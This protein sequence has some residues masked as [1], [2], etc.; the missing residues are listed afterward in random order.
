M[1][2]GHDVGDGCRLFELAWSKRRRYQNSCDIGFRRN[3]AGR[4]DGALPWRESAARIRPEGGGVDFE[5]GTDNDFN[6]AI[7]DVQVRGPGVFTNSRVCAP[8]GAVMSIDVSFFFPPVTRIFIKR[9]RDNAILRT[10]ASN[11]MPG[12]HNGN[13]FGAGVY[14]TNPADG[15]CFIVTI[16]RL[17]DSVI[18]PS[19][20]N[21]DTVLFDVN[22]DGQFGEAKIKASYLLLPIVLP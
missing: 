19:Q 3:K 5:D 12:T 8:P 16:Q 11:L 14:T 17:G 1:G 2:I 9:T 20:I 4:P 15:S 10:F 7:V 18:V 21:G 22:R 13:I 6:D